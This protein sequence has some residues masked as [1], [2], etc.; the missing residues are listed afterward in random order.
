[1]Q[2]TIS[3]K[4]VE[5]GDALQSRVSA[6]L[7]ESVSKYFDQALEASVVFS[8]S[9]STLFHCD[10]T[11]HVGH[12]IR[13]RGEGEAGDA[14]AAFDLAQEHIAKRLRRHK[15]RL[16]NHRAGIEETDP[17]EAAQYILAAE[18]PEGDAGEDSGS[19]TVVIAEM[20]TAVDTMTV[21]SAV[22]RLDLSDAPVVVFRNPAHGGVNVVYKRSDGNIGWID[23]RGNQTA[24]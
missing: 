9:G 23:P 7:D 13:M 15:R 14:H 8:R 22:M 10:I 6:E 12:N 5:L 16:R 18:E 21:G 1:M 20:T 19:D 11:V 4:Q 3:G 17:L 24:G 2:I